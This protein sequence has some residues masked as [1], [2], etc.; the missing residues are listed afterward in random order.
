MMKNKPLRINRQG[1]CT[2]ISGEAGGFPQGTW[3]TLVRLQGC[4]LKC[5]WCDT[6]QARMQSVITSLEAGGDL[7]NFIEVSVPDLVSQ[8]RDQMNPH[9][10]ITG[11]EPLMQPEVINL[12]ESLVER[13]FKVQVETNG[14]ILIPFIPEVYWVVDFKCPSS[15]MVERMNISM[16]VWAGQIA[17]QQN[18]GGHVSVK[19]VVMD[20]I[21]LDYAIEAIER[22][23]D[24]GVKG[25]FLISPINAKG[26][27]IKGMAERI[28]EKH[29]G[30]LDHIVFSVQLHK[31]FGMV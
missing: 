12:I 14:S 24:Y 16:D 21:D 22:L 10:L 23:L 28:R 31:V 29:I 11:G 15:G 1:L 13:G 25:P 3:I 27:N 17:R 4:N 18:A 7:R 19:F 9:V 5:T 30:L 2:T 26:E 8:I 6:P 20:V